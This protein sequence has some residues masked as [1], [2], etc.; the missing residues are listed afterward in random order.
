M[1]AVFPHGW[2]LAIE[3]DYP[4]AAWLAEFIRTKRISPADEELAVEL[5]DKLREALDA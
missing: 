5:Y 4:S 1:F 2:G 3:A